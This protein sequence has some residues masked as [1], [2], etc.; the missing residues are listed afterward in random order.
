MLSKIENGAQ[1]IPNG[2]TW[3]IPWLRP[4]G[5]LCGLGRR[6]TQWTLLRFCWIQNGDS[7]AFQARAVWD[8]TGGPVS[9]I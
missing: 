1:S 5:R 9:N 7:A 6:C 3:E 8:C 4:L 2:V